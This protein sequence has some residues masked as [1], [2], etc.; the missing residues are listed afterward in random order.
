VIFFDFFVVTKIF[1]KY[2]SKYIGE[3]YM[4]LYR[5]HDGEEGGGMFIA[6]NIKRSGGKTYTSV[7]LR[8]SYR[9]N[10]K[11]KKRTIAN[12]SHCSEEQINAISWGLKNKGSTPTSGGDFKIIQ[13]RSIG[14]VYVLYEIANR[15]GIVEAL[16]SSFQAQLAL[17]LIIARIIEQGSRLSAT[18]LD[19][20]FDIASVIGLK[21][22]FDE[23]NLYDCL[24]WL[25]KNQTEIE[26]SLF[27]RKKQPK[28]FYW[29]DVT[30][31]YLEG[32]CNELSAF[33]YNRD[34]K[35]RKRII[36]VG[37]LCQEGGD[38]ISIEAFKGNTQDTQT[39]ENQ[40]IK[41]K[42]RFACESVTI[43]CD[44]GIIREKQKKLLAKY[45]FRYITALP[46]R[47]IT[48]LLDAKIIV[49][50]E[51]TNELQSK[52]HGNR[53]YIYRCN[54]QRALETQAQRQERL[55]TAQRRIN[56]ENLRLREKPKSSPYTT[57]KRTQK[58]LK[59][60]Y[61]HEWVTIIIKNRQLFLKIDEK[62]LKI[63]SKFDGCYIWTTDWT[64][65]EISDREIYE[66]YKN[67]K[68]IEEDFRIFKTTFLEIRPLFV[69]T[70][71][72]TRGHL[73]VIMLA[74]MIV[75]ELRKAWEGLDKTVME[76]LRELSLLC[77][78]TIQWSGGQEIE[79][80]PVP[81]KGMS[82]LLKALNIML[83]QALEEKKVPVVT[84]HKVRKSVK[85]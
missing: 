20:Q 9:E 1:F 78:Q 31:S 80:I 59:R 4:L 22:G 30:S 21:R 70:A 33:G 52:V 74:H 51:F 42:T 72:S 79:C 58:Y 27:K 36:V 71:E 55:D 16:G 76:G 17:W 47:Q 15:L 69:R 63:K 56:Q 77:R 48:P 5:V 38:P 34:Q 65:E 75:R 53:R 57:K 2:F 83:P 67:L 40:L 7:L 8:E 39:F 18:R 26:N 81:N 14:S 13:G 19:N 64:E 37:L 32:A 49:A 45:G 41:L 61:L 46:M 23:N 12:L 11:V 3:K 10:N 84:R 29:Y 85:N 6:K 25:D 60:L 68:Y 24:H 62:A 44:R 43:I 50:E 35:K 54:P 82:E 28:R 73:L 66:Q